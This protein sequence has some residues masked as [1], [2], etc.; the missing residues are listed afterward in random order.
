MN[1]TRQT[2]RMVLCWFLAATLATTAPCDVDAACTFN[3]DLIA[4]TSTF[5]PN[6]SPAETY[7]DLGI[8]ALHRGRTVFRS[9]F[10]SGVA[11]TV[12]GNFDRIDTGLPG[13][14]LT[15]VMRAQPATGGLNGQLAGVT[16]DPTIYNGKVGWSGATQGGGGVFRTSGGAVIYEAGRGP[17]FSKTV[18][19]LI[20]S[21][22]IVG[23]NLAFP[24]NGGGGSQ[25]RT[26]GAAPSST[27]VDSTFA[28]PG[29]PGADFAVFTD[30]VDYNVSRLAFGGGWFP[31]NDFNKP[32]EIGIYRWD[33]STG[34]ATAVADKNV[35]IPAQPGNFDVGFGFYTTHTSSPTGSSGS[36]SSPV[37]P[38]LAGSTVA[39]S[40]D[41]GSRTGV[42]R[43]LNGSLK[44]VADVHTKHPTLP[45]NFAGFDGVSTLGGATAFI[46]HD[47]AG[48]EGLYL[49]MC[50]RIV[51][52][53]REGSTYFGSPVAEV[54]LGHRGLAVGNPFSLKTSTQL[55]FRL[56]FQNGSSAV[57][58]ASTDCVCADMGTVV[59]NTGVTG[60]LGN[61]SF[62]GKV[63]AEDSDLTMHVATSTASGTAAVFQADLDAEFYG[64]D[65]EPGN[66]PTLIDYTLDGGSVVPELMEISFNQDVKLTA[67]HLEELGLS[68]SA[69]LALPGDA[70]TVDVGNATNG[71]IDLGD[72]LLREGDTLGIGWDP[73][74]RIGDGFSFNGLTIVPVPE[75]TTFALTGLAAAIASLLGVRR[76]RA[77]SERS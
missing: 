11:A 2:R 75:P 16:Y 51:E 62:G 41:D 64:I 23:N 68:D 72:V 22:T 14:I 67:L 19:G 34:S 15:E 35:S 12:Q 71:M 43:H 5:V 49:A 20:G 58:W 60:A 46:G 61:G 27:L 9:N 74:N 56:E 13:A 44:R 17:G 10:P 66:E 33:W 53:V 3:F 37:R 65:A 21:A 57:Y 8:P 28:V 59:S 18:Q 29:A 25:V 26:A 30:Y 39:F 48:V 55:A 47:A 40:Y 54:E 7:T 24:L 50:N 52:V 73:G 45:G 76:R 32:L 31:N 70:R 1:D 77:R 4:D 63:F 38:S 69:L 36:S 6:Q 42:Y